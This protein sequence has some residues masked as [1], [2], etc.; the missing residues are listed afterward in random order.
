MYSALPLR[1]GASRCTPFYALIPYFLPGIT[2]RTARKTKE[3]GG[4]VEGR[5]E[6]GRKEGRKVRGLIRVSNIRRKPAVAKRRKVTYEPMAANGRSRDASLLI[7]R[8]GHLLE[9]NSLLFPIILLRSS[10]NF[11]GRAPLL[12]HRSKKFANSAPMMRIKL[13]DYS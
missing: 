6:E 7:H 13:Y 11:E 9:K 2:M 12:V 1:P 10:R 5:K 4:I 3:A 8:R